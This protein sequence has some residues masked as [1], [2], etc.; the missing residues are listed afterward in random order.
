MATT[1]GIHGVFVSIST[2]AQ[3]P[4]DQP[5]ITNQFIGFRVYH[6]RPDG[7]ETWGW[8]GDNGSASPIFDG[9]RLRTAGLDVTFQPDQQRWSGTWLL[10]GETRAVVLEPPRPASASQSNVMRGEWEVARDSIARVGFTALHILQ[11]SGRRYP[12]CAV[13]VGSRVLFPAMVPPCQGTGPP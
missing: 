10:D 3:G 5:V 1:S 12:A 9:R 4:P 8:Y 11:S 13:R 7:Y 6:R 2:H